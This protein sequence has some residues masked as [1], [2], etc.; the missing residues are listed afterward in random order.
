MRKP[1]LRELGEAVRAV[2]KGPYTVRFPFAPP[3]VMETFR[4][5][6]EFV[7]E[8]CV[9]CG[10]CAEVC[11]AGA[12]QRVDDTAAEPPVRRF[13]LHYDA[14]IFCGQCVLNCTTGEGIKQTTE[15]DLAAFDR[16]ECVHRLE[17]EL[18]VCEV[19][20]GVVGTVDHLR[21][22]ARRVGP[23]GYANPNLILIAHS[24]LDLTDEAISPRPDQQ[25]YRRADIMRF[26]CPRCRRAVI[27]REVWG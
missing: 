10:A 4:G 17:K 5:K 19:C 3:E 13:E 6:P 26:L 14:C 25:P 23:K 21:W 2:I 15:F 24:E 1:K 7:E 20:G 12:I 11:P 9:G 8:K 22:V 16:A 18:V 27:V